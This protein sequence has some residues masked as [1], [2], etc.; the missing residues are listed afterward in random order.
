MWQP[1]DSAETKAKS[2]IVTGGSTRS[3]QHWLGI[4][5]VYSDSFSLNV[6][7]PRWLFF[8]TV[9]LSDHIKQKGMNFTTT[10]FQ[11]SISLPTSLPFYLLAYGSAECQKITGASVTSEFVQWDDEDKG[12]RNDNSRVVPFSVRKN[13]WNTRIYFCYYQ[14]KISSKFRSWF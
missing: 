7:K 9:S 10:F 3:R 4:N 1:W 13:R 11:T 2:T 6:G 12:N 14:F 5:C 8:K